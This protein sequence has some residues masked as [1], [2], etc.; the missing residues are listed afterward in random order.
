M[1]I[2]KGRSMLRKMAQFALG[3]PDSSS[4]F[5]IAIVRLLVIVCPRHAEGRW[6]LNYYVDSVFQTFMQNLVHIR[7]FPNL[8]I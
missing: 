2:R 5:L 7:W 3:F 6:C 8:L 4:Q 1:A